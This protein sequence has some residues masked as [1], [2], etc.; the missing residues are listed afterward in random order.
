[1][2]RD[3]LQVDQPAQGQGRA[4]LNDGELCFTKLAAFGYSAM[5]IR[6]RRHLIRSVARC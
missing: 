2:N 3:L 4:N 6:E 5:T 1:M